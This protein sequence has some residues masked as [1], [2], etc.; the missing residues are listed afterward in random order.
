MPQPLHWRRVRTAEWRGAALFQPV[1]PVGT[2]ALVSGAVAVVEDGVVAVVVAAVQFMPATKVKATHR[3][4]QR[5]RQAVMRR[6]QRLRTRP[7]R[8]RRSAVGTAV[9]AGPTA[10]AAVGAADTVVVRLGRQLRRRLAARPLRATLLHLQAALSADVAVAE[11][12]LAVVVVEVAA[13]AVVH[14]RRVARAVQLLVATR[15]SYFHRGVQLL[16][17]DPHCPGFYCAC[18]HSHSLTARF[19]STPL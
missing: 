9:D 8:I 19:F 10:V 4:R 6:L 12:V 1:V 2:A 14:P 11:V 17:L 7:R 5:L 15:N 18:A 3:S 16:V 13:V